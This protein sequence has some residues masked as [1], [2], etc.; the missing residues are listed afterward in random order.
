MRQQRG[1]TTVA[2]ATTNHLKH[3][4]RL[5]PAPACLT[6]EPRATSIVRA[7][8]EVVFILRNDRA[9][10]EEITMEECCEWSAALGPSPP[11]RGVWA[12]VPRALWP[13]DACAC[14]FN[15]YA[16]LEY[17]TTNEIAPVLAWGYAAG[18]RVKMRDT[19]PRP[20]LLDLRGRAGTINAV[21]EGT[22]HVIFDAPFPGP[23][24]VRTLSALVTDFE[25]IPD[26]RPLIDAQWREEHPEEL[27]RLRRHPDA[28]VICHERPDVWSSPLNG[29]LPT[30]CPHWACG[31]CWSEIAERDRRC[32][33]CRDDLTEWLEAEF[34]QRTSD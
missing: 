14:F 34:G 27:S 26:S 33:I 6:A 12:T 3:N 31:A 25:S 24:E 30:R 2:T 8:E 23:P 32:P 9:R 22:L 15:A 28:C 21:N 16:F 19:T 11:E 29:D 17:I 5:A 18:D 1:A 4:A 7:M 13:A 10:L 20:E